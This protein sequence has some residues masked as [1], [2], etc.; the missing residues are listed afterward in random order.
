MGGY[1]VRLDDGS[2]I[3]PLD[4]AS[5]RSWFNDGLINPESQVLT[6]G[7]RR[8]AP[9]RQAID[10][11][12]WGGTTLR[13]KT[14][15]GG[16]SVAD[17]PEAYSYSGSDEPF[18]ERL[19]APLAGA[20]LIAGAAIAG[21]W[22]W[23]PEQQ[24]AAMHAWPW[25]EIGLGL[26][27]LGLCLFVRPRVTRRLVFA[28]L[29]LA[30]IAALAMVGVLAVQNASSA[31]YFVLGSGICACFGFVA[32]LEGANA[33]WLR[34]V[35][36][37]LVVI[38]AYGTTL[39]MGYV[40]KDQMESLVYTWVL[41]Q[42]ELTDTRVGM[43]LRLPAGW[44][45]IKA[46]AP[47]LAAPADAVGRMARQDASAYAYLTAERVPAGVLQVESLGERAVAARRLVVPSL[48]AIERTA[49]QIGGRPTVRVVGESGSFSAPVNECVLVWRDGFTLY[50]LVGWGEAVSRAE[51][52][53]RFDELAT[54]FES[55]AGSGTRLA[56][57]VGK[58][59]AEVMF[60]SPGTA[61]RLMS[62]SDAG[63]IEPAQLFKRA[64]VLG[65]RGIPR[66][67][68]ADVRELQNILDV[69]YR[70]MDRRD[71]KRL[72]DYL[73]QIR[74]TG[75]SEPAEDREMCGVMGRAVAQL[76]AVSRQRLQTLYDQ[77]IQAALAEPGASAA[78]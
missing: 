7:S 76:S 78:P 61:E 50:T 77:T 37:S 13:A 62:A 26:L 28:G 19:R 41:P 20:L 65:G 44:R 25:K 14:R 33:S 60:V 34:T 75:T 57:A 56:D 31:A 8:W 63:I 27:A 51:M 17:E 54:G 43:K 35:I 39:K 70:G 69:T 49:V 53:G 71:R 47:F 52:A 29:L 74:G 58:A 11:R 2:E 4:L 59:V 55:L 38:A 1:K 15:R 23:W 18:V 72:A 5:V 40:S 12:A 46:G 48:R 64:L 3:G 36:G 24:K 42:D 67:A 9:L 68:P 66:L 45:F 6:P 10:I 30:G 73:A 22:V 32:L 21:F 16:A